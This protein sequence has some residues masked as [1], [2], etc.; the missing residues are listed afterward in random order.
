MCLIVHESQRTQILDKDLTVY[1]KILEDGISPFMFFK[2]ESDILYSTSIA[3][4][5]DMWCYD[6]QAY[7]NTKYGKKWRT[8]P[9]LVSLEEGFHFALSIERLES[10]V[11]ENE[12]IVEC[13]IPAGSMMYTED[14][15]GIANNIIVHF[16]KMEEYVFNN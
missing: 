16:P 9:K 1:K 12:I 7:Y 11:D 3:A 10:S 13:T 14:G 8:N 15:L 4:G 2:Y 6:N 5:D